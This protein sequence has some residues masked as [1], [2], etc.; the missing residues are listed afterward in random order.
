MSFRLTILSSKGPRPHPCLHLTLE[1][2]DTVGFRKPSS[3]SWVRREANLL[4]LMGHFPISTL[5]NG[6][7]WPPKLMSSRGWAPGRGCPLAS[8]FGTAS[9][10]P[11]V[12]FLP[13]S[14]APNQILNPYRASPVWPAH[15]FCHEYGYSLFSL[16]RWQTS[17][18]VCVHESKPK[19]CALPRLQGRLAVSEAPGAPG[20]P[21]GG[22]Y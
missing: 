5:I 6:F 8:L 19:R 14:G 9:H 18:N 12:L 22:G 1:A 7:C 17:K 3:L 21:A 16:G 2:L 13:D 4:V 10:F 15:S 20:A 11:G